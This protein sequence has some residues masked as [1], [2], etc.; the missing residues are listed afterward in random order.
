MKHAIRNFIVASVTAIASS[1]FAQGTY[2]YKPI[3]IG[4][5]DDGVSEAHAINSSGYVTGWSTSSTG[6]HAFLWHQST[7]IIDLD[8]ADDYG[9][10]IGYGIGEDNAVVGT[11]SLGLPTTGFWFHDAGF[12]LLYNDNSEAQSATY[13]INAEESLSVGYS[14]DDPS[15]TPASYVAYQWDEPSSTPHN[16]TNINPSTAIASMAFG[17]NAIS[18]K[19]GVAIYDHITNLNVAWVT[20]PSLTNLPPLSSGLNAFAY[21][22]ND[23]DYVVGRSEGSDTKDH[24]VYWDLLNNITALGFADSGDDFAQA[25]RVNNGLTIVGMSGLLSGA[26]V[27]TKWEAS[28][29]TSA[30][31]L[32]TVIDGCAGWNLIEA[33]DVNDDGWIVGIGTHS[34]VGLRGFLLVPGPWTDDQLAASS[35][36]VTIGSVSSGNTASLADDDNNKLVVDQSTLPFPTSPFAK[37]QFDATLPGGLTFPLVTGKLRLVSNM[38][39]SGTFNQKVYLW[40]WV[41]S[42]WDLVDDQTL[43]TSELTVS[44][45]FSDSQA[46]YVSG[47]GAVRALVEVKHTGGF[48]SGTPKVSFDQASWFYMDSSF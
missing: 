10:T 20:K 39:V 16:G 21:G 7:G 2:D 14:E 6:T 3:D 48:V 38:G 41:G 12:Y 15:D 22:L 36:T 32:N 43:G 46:S 40:N 33:R 28:V 11:S 4:S 9:V 13:D 27:A 25:N 5:V 1:L 8:P 19:C 17:I 35:Y 18:S 44:V 31:D 24:A 37:I 23:D 26:K 47:G 45:C 34:V 42:S 29:S 30:I